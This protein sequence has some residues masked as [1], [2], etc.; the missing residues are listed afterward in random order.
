MGGM[1]VEERMTGWEETTDDEPFLKEVQKKS[2][3]ITTPS[4]SFRSLH[5]GSFTN[6]I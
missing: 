3:S 4:Q 2:I 1:F 6:H 5:G